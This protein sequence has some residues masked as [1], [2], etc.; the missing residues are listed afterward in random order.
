M[1]G[2]GVGVDSILWVV[3][4]QGGGGLGGPAMDFVCNLRCL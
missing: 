4:L 1:M 2:A 3:G